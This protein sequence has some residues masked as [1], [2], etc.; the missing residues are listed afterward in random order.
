M[1]INGGHNSKN[2]SVK[3]QTKPRHSSSLMVWSWVTNPDL[4]SGDTDA[5]YLQWQLPVWFYPP[6]P[7]GLLWMPDM[8]NRTGTPGSSR[9]ELKGASQIILPTSH[10]CPAL[11]EI[12]EWR[13]HSD[14]N[15]QAG[16]IVNSWN[17]VELNWSDISVFQTV[18]PF[19]QITL[20]T[21]LSFLTEQL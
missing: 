17:D 16:R 12:Q 9:A 2:T 8:E 5:C 4:A 3:I 11:T 7:S 15:H 1:K 6:V 18:Q 14:R 20:K 19:L 10:R 21:C 13:N